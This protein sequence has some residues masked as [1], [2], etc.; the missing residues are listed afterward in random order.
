MNQL[1]LTILLAAISAALIAGALPAAAADDTVIVTGAG[2]GHGVGMSQYGA[3]G[4]AQEGRTAGEILTYYYTGTSVTDVGTVIPG[5]WILASPE[6]L[7]VNLLYSKVSSTVT[8]KDGD[9]TVCQNEPASLLLKTGDD[10]YWVSVLESS[11]LATG[12][13]IG[14]P[15]TVFDAET[16]AAVMAYQTEH[17]LMVD[18]I[19]GPQTRSSLWP[20]DENGENCA[21][22]LPLLSGTSATISTGPG[23]SCTWSIAPAEGSCV[24]SLRGLSPSSRV[25][26]STKYYGSKIQEFAHGTMRFRP[27]GTGLVHVVIQIGIEDYVAGINEVPISWPDASLQTQAIAARS[28][29]INRSL[30]RGPE[31]GFST[32]TTNSCWCHLYS[33]TLSQVYSGWL[34]ETDSSGRWDT[35]ARGTSGMVVSHSSVG[36]VP[37]FY[38]SSTGGYTDDNENAWGG[39]AL[40][41]LRS[42]PDPWSLDPAINPNYAWTRSFAPSSIASAFGFTSVHRIEVTAHNSSGTA[43]TVRIDGVKNDLITTT[44]VS[45]GT[46][47]SALGLK[48]RYFDVD[49]TGTPPPP[50]GSDRPVLHN[51]TTGQWVYRSLDGTLSSIYYGVPG[52]VAFMGDWN[53]DGVDT[54]GLYRR[55]DGYVYLRNSNTQGVADV[56]YFFG[57]PGDMPLAGDFNGDGCDTVSIYRPSEARFYIINKLGSADGGLGA[58]DYSFLYGVGGD[59]AFVGDWNGDGIDTPGLR[60]SSNGFVYLRDA[61]T[62]GVANIEFFYGVS[63][64]VVF[65]GDWDADGADSI[66]LYRPSNG[67]IYLRNTNTTGVA[68][69]SFWVGTGMQPVAGDF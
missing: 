9:L 40:A 47:Q 20:T 16:K 14:T 19:V 41:Y 54:P 8:A 62:Q 35:L 66:G 27:N 44:T 50:D 37:T 36:V 33:T 32:S 26:L 18:G 52:D 45:G 60:R 30:L 67:T 5:S 39:A 69:Y 43:K 22:S 34:R 29:G 2:W 56:S 25:A 58:A 42:V 65:S 59:V 68:N 4:Q 12:H 15:D 48:S 13:F 57:V 3:K 61:N 21:L 55:S 1:R 64:D 6:P 49:W 31:P 24:S 51:G 17:G 53:C 38:S 63:G 28:Y 23:T 46:F 11:L 7:W 10:S